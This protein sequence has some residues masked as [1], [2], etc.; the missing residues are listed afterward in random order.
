MTWVRRSIENTIVQC[1]DIF[2]SRRKEQMNDTLHLFTLHEDEQ[3]FRIKGSVLARSPQEAAS[4]LGGEFIEVENWPPGSS[5]NPD[6]LSLFGK[7]RFAPELFRQ[8]TNKEL[9]RLKIDFTP[10]KVHYEKWLG[11][12]LW[13]NPGEGVELVLRRS[14]IVFPEYAIS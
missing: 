13:A 5:T 10:S 12:V 8:F 6:E 2:S 1:Y 4:I 14:F 7:I 11:L 9:F 3:D